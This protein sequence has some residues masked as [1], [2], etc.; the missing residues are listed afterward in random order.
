MERALMEPEVISETQTH[1]PL[2]PL[3]FR[4]GYRLSDGRSEVQINRGETAGVPADHV[5]FLLRQQIAVAPGAPLDPPPPDVTPTAVRLLHGYRT[6]S[7]QRFGP[8]RVTLPRFEADPLIAADGAVLDDGKDHIE[9][10]SPVTQ[11]RA[12]VRARG[13]QLAQQILER[14]R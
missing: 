5:G 2:V 11:L 10:E 13:R 3:T 12:R 6:L 14:Y 9:P 7:G 8:E 4:C 1:Q